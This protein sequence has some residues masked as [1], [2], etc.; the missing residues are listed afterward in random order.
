MRKPSQLRATSLAGAP[1]RPGSPPSPAPGSGFPQSPWRSSDAGPTCHLLFKKGLDGLAL[2]G[3]VGHGL[4]QQ[5]PAAHCGGGGG[6]R[7]VIF[8]QEGEREKDNPGPGQGRGVE[9]AEQNREGFLSGGVSKGRK[10]EKELGG[11]RP[12]GKVQ[13]QDSFCKERKTQ[14]MARP[15]QAPASRAGIPTGWT[16]EP[17][18]T[19]APPWSL[20]AAAQESGDQA[21]QQTGLQQRVEQVLGGGS[22]AEGSPRAPR[23]GHG[24]SSG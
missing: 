9:V 7:P 4:L 18:S 2:P 3:V 20:H 13:K 17:T 22:R 6:Q 1:R 24:V 23:G 15:L 19:L 11:R 21:E 16:P 12:R 10:L 14:Y 8:Q 5:L